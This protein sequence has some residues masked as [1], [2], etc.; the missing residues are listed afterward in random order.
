MVQNYQQRGPVQWLELMDVRPSTHKVATTTGVGTPSSCFLLQYA[1]RVLNPNKPFVDFKKELKK[2]KKN[3]GTLRKVTK[4]PVEDFLY[5]TD[6]YC[7]WIHCFVFGF[8]VL[9][10]FRDTLTDHFISSTFLVPVWMDLSPRNG[11]P[12]R[13]LLGIDLTRSW[14]HS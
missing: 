5:Q 10:L 11:L 2:I 1:D 8:C 14:K 6:L 12:L 3:G 9:F 4:Q 13:S 7:R